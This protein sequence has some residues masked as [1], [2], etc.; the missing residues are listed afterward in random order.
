[1]ETLDRTVALD[2]DR[3]KCIGCG[4]CMAVC[5][6]GTLSLE[7]G[8]ATVSGSE[9]LSCGHCEAVCPEAAIR[10]RTLMN[11]SQRFTTFRQR[12]G[13]VA[14]GVT[15]VADLVQLMRSR[16]SCRN[17]RDR[18]VPLDVLQDIVRIGLT[19]PSGSN[20]QPWTFTL[21]PSRDAVMQL[22][23]LVAAF[24]RRLNRTADRRLLRLALKW[25]GRG[26]LDFYYN[27]YRDDVAEALED[28]EQKGRDLLFHG[29]PAV[30]LVGTRPGASCPSEDAL[31]ATQNMLLGAHAM[32]LGTCLIGFAVS[33][34]KQDPGMLKHLDIP[35]GERVYAVIA[36][37]YPNTKE[38]YHRLAG[39][40]PLQCRIWD[41]PWLGASP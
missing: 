35:A 33:A 27:N 24:F 20:C 1:M 30:I 6:S 26:E 7:N 34:F 3:E 11:D 39:R 31:L 23:D 41:P 4:A 38:T 17:F 9:S 25:I 5:P 2:I 32:G 29:A 10:V 21:V 36:L 18:P 14:P 28:W 37:G 12:S 8:K 40:K 19:A 13:W 15:D 16:R 22:G